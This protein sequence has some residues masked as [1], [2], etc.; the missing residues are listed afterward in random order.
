MA[1]LREE[2]DVRTIVNA[3]RDELQKVYN[4]KLGIEY[5]PREKRLSADEH[6]I[7][8]IK[9]I[10]GVEIP[11]AGEVIARIKSNNCELHCYTYN[12]VAHELIQ[13]NF[14]EKITKINYICY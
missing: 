6:R 12:P 5:I 8:I 4:K 7:G 13:N 1:G 9:K 10:L 14:R 3:I 2:N 11:F